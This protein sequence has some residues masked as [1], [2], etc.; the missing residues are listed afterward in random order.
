[1]LACLCR[2]LHSGLLCLPLRL[3]RRLQLLRVA[4]ELGMEGLFHL[5]SQS[6]QTFLTLDNVAAV[7]SFTIEHGFHDLERVCRAFVSAGGKTANPFRLDS[8]ASRMDSGSASLREAIASSLKDVNA[9]LGQHPPPAAAKLKVEPRAVATAS[10]PTATFTV[11]PPQATTTSKMPQ[12]AAQT[13]TS[14]LR[15][16]DD[17][18]DD[19]ADPYD[20]S[21]LSLMDI[22]SGRAALSREN[23]Y[24][25]DANTKYADV[26]AEYSEDYDFNEYTQSALQSAYGATGYSSAGNKGSKGKGKTGSGGIYGLLL[27]SSEEAQLYEGPTGAGVGGGVR[28][29]PSNKVPGRVA[30]EKR[31]VPQSAGVNKGLPAAQK[32]GGAAADVESTPRTQRATSLLANARPSQYSEYDQHVGGWDDGSVNSANIRRVRGPQEFEKKMSLA[33]PRAMTPNEKR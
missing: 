22:A 28:Q 18:P 3:S 11:E 15:E 30:G 25:V 21:N 17:H 13:N 8:A 29:V 7:L 19:G 12:R 27:Q 32:T 1:M 5:A 10:I 26:S 2:Y 23:S 16:L 6:V 9:V 4:S 20:L 33:P 24:S 14:L 31:T